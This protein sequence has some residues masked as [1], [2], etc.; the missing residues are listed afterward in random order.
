[1]FQI[2]VALAVDQIVE[3]RRTRVEI[4]KLCQRAEHEFAKVP[5]GIMDQ[6]IVSNAREC[7]A[8]LL[9]CRS[10]VRVFHLGRL[11]STAQSALGN[12]RYS[13]GQ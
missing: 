10:L 9:D 11:L 8:L 1:M 5:C 6:F 2:A 4:A 12:P 7:H 13:V 3:R